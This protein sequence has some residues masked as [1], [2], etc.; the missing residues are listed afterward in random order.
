MMIRSIILLIALVSP[1]FAFELPSGSSQC[2]VGVADDWDSSSVVLT[3]YQKEKGEWKAAS[4]P[5]KGRLGKKGMAWGL[6]FHPVPKGGEMKKEGDWKTPAGVFKLGGVW[7]YER[8]VKKH[9]KMY[10]RQIT[11]RD[12]WVEDP[13]SKHYNRHLVLKHEPSS[14][15]E[16]QQQMRQDD[17]AHSLKLFIGHNA[18]PK[19]VS[20]AGSSIF[21]HIW[22]DGGARPTAG[23]TVM[24]RSKLEWMISKIDP[25]KRPL[26]VLLPKAEYEKRRKDW[27]LP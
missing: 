7:G 26:Y 25:I 11:S 10:Y 18:P 22:R 21:F 20:G 17:P 27:K 24:D 4:E 14:S 8:S 2:L 1:T 15:W 13:D 12:L 6:G 5:W 23:C 9:P 3:L 19:V 16:K